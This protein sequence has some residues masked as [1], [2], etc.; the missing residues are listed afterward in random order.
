[1]ML[2]QPGGRYTAT[3]VSVGMLIQNAYR[4]QS[5]QLVGG[6]TWLTVDRFDIVARAG[7][8]LGA[9][10]GAQNQDP[11]PLQ[12]M[13]RG[14]LADRFKLAFHHETR[15]LPV[16]ALV[17]ARSDR[18]LG[19]Q[20]RATTVDC[21]ALAA[22]RGRG[23]APSGPPRPD[24][25]PTCGMSGGLGNLVAGSATLSQLA[26]ALSNFLN[27][28]VLDQTGVTGNFDVDLYV[29]AGSDAAAVRR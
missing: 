14:L 1:M 5:F 12:L 15:E 22:A 19:P 8:D 27:R 17:L 4:L 23:N 11:T 29:D 24:Q 20:L 21:A 25:R 16:Y 26:N 28:T 6:P 10:V 13:M 9:V 3:N 2:N 18:R 7:G